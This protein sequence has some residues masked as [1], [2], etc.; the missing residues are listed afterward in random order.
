LPGTNPPLAW[1]SRTPEAIEKPSREPSG[2]FPP[3]A[4]L[5]LRG[6]L[7]SSRASR[8]GHVLHARNSL[9]CPSTPPQRLLPQLAALFGV[10]CRRQ[11]TKESTSLE[12]R[13]LSAFADRVPLSAS[14]LWKDVGRPSPRSSEAPSLGFGYPYDGFRRR[15]PWK[16]IS[17]PNAPRLCPFKASLLLRGPDHLS[18]TRLRSYAFS[19]N[20]TALSRRFSGLIPRGKPSHQPPN[21]LGWGEGDAFL[22]FRTSRALPSKR[23]T[24]RAFPLFV[25]LTSLPPRGL[26]TTQ[27]TDLRGLRPP[28]PGCL[29]PKRAPARL[30]FPTDSI[31]D[32]FE[33]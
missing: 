32:P 14:F 21:V 7:G 1:F 27:P 16:H 15:D 31:H 29:P 28:R 26:S 19:Q 24:K 2:S 9:S 8:S 4:S 25:P 12:L 30:A 11:S 20:L 22:G 23:S 5:R 6:T 18:M 10:F 33:E 17:A 3:P 13:G